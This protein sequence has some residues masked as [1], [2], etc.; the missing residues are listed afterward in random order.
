MRHNCLFFKRRSMLHALAALLLACG[1]VVLVFTRPAA[2]EAAG[3]ASPG[4]GHW[5]ARGDLVGDTSLIDQAIGAWVASAGPV[6]SDHVLLAQSDPV[7]GRV[8]VLEGRVATLTGLRGQDAGGA[9]ELRDD[10]SAVDLARQPGLA[11][12]I[13]TREAQPDD[14]RVAV[15]LARPG[16]TALGLVSSA[17]DA[18]TQQA[19]PTDLA[20]TVLPADATPA[21]TA[22]RIDLGPSDILLP[23]AAPSRDPA[24][25]RVGQA[26]VYYVPSSYAPAADHPTDGKSRSSRLYADDA[27]ATIVIAEQRGHDVTGA[28]LLSG[29]G[30]ALAPANAHAS[31][32]M[33]AVAAGAHWGFAWTNVSRTLGYSV[34]ATGGDAQV[35]A[36]HVAQALATP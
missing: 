2:T 30:G 13:T 15:V 3:A 36:Y 1:A 29:L 16:A 7:L 9:L 4:A 6:R 21:N 19:G 32:P 28:G 31:A 23:L 12:L 33:T 10:R 35:A 11:M 17:F 14:S 22:A 5:V 18:Y 24:P 34:V 25:D 27:G 20:I 8:V 26:R